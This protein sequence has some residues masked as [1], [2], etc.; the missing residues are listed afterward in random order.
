M[1]SLDDWNN[2]AWDGFHAPVSGPSYS[3]DP[4]AS[5]EACSSACGAHSTCFQWTYHHQKC[6]F[7]RSIRFGKHQEPSIIEPPNEG[8][9]PR[10]GTV[11]GRFKAG[12]ATEDIIQ[13]MNDRPCERVQ[14]VRP[15]TDRIF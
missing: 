12:W 10:L 2:A 11:D 8:E 7:V 9:P 14:W 4:H 15:S 6:T 5:V 3:H 13:W 1:T